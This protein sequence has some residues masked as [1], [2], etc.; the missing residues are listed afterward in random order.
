[1]SVD[2]IEWKKAVIDGLIVAHIYRA[3]HE[4]NPTMALNDLLCWTQQVALDPAV[5]SE[6]QA[7]LDTVPPSAVL[8]SE[9]LYGFAGWLTCR[10]DPVTIGSTHDAAPVADLVNEFCT[11]QEF[12][13]PRDDVY[14][15][16][17]KRYPV[18]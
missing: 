5:S 13:H 15:N 3:E 9:A 2:P 17:L 7:L 12:E 8:P 11:S 6:A 4:N 14:P 1:M 16:N 18:K 10:R